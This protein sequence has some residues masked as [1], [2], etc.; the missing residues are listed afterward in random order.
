[1]KLLASDYDG[2]LY[3]ED[4]YKQEDLEAIRAFQKQGNM[5]GLCS[6]RPLRN[7]WSLQSEALKFDF[8]IASSGASFATDP[9]HVLEERTVPLV[10]LEEIEE[11]M[12]LENVVVVGKTRFFVQNP[13]CWAAQNVGQNVETIH[14]AKQV[15]EPV[16]QISMELPS[17]AAA[18]AMCARLARLEQPCSFFQNG[19]FIDIVAA[20]CSKATGIKAVA[21]ALGI[22]EE[23]VACIGDNFNDLP[24]IEGIENSFSFDFA[25][26]AVQERAGTIVSSVAEAIACWTGEGNLG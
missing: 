2:T 5:F 8:I 26:A 7:L 13:A 23:D 1:M 19:T 4:G 3:F 20:G 16:L 12:G 21:A 17:E 6:G 10:V 9:E 11:R 15:Q 25:P 22:A 24:M 18:R 14:S